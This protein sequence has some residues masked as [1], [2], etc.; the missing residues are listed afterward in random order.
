[1]KN[2]YLFP[3]CL[4]LVIVLAARASDYYLIPNNFFLHKGEKL[5]LRLLLGDYFENEKGV[6]YQSAATAKLVLHTGSKNTV[7]LKGI[8]KDADSAILSNYKLENT[9]LQLIEMDQVYPVVELDRA[10]LIKELDQEQLTKLSEKA[11]ASFQQDIRERYTTYL[12]T[13]FTV[14][15][16]NGTVFN[17]ELG[18]TL[19]IILEEN[20]YKLGYGDDVT[21]LV[22][23]KG[24]PLANA[25]VDLVVKTSAGKIHP[26]R[27]ASDAS[28]HITFKLSLEGT[29]MLR[30]VNIDVTKAKD[31]DYEKWGAA[32]TFAFANTRKLPD[33]Y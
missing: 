14:D 23:F 29:Y 9:G 22:K 27:L 6:Q 15:K 3:L 30:T 5:I 18:Q 28:G 11:S 17:K 33:A 32:Y 13:L 7:D 24:A 4:L 16:P 20:P 25:H 1:M 8:A 26:E 31:V 19:E 2:K 12:K 21:A 10:A